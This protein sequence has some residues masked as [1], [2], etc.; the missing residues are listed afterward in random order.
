MACGGSKGSPINPRSSIL[1]GQ[2]TFNAANQYAKLGQLEDALAA[3]TSAAE[4]G[5]RAGV[6]AALRTRYAVAFTKY[7]LG[8]EDG[9]IEELAELARPL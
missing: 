2:L 4:V 3:F 8:R 6:E 5:E 9:L 7:Q 1:R